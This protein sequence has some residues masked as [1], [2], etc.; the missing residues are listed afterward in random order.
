MIDNGRDDVA[1]HCVDS[2]PE[3][4]VSLTSR[5]RLATTLDHRQP[6]HVCVDLGAYTA[7]GICAAPLS[8]LRRALTGD[9]TFRV[10]LFEPFLGLGEVDEPV[11]RAI[12]A[13][14][15]GLWT[16][17]TIMGFRNA[18]WKPWTVPD[19]TPVLV[20]SEF[21]PAEGANG[22]LL[23]YPGNDRTVAPSARMLPGGYYFD[24]IIRQEPI[25]DDHLDPSGNREDFRILPD[26]LVADAARDAE[27]LWT[28]TDYA[29]F[30]R[31]PGLWFTDP[32]MCAGPGLKHSRGIRDEV[33]WL[34]SLATRRDLIHAI[35]EHETEIALQNL[36]RLASA[37]GDR[38]AVVKVCSAD[39]GGQAATLISR[40]T[41][42]E[43]FSPYYR[44]LNAAFHE[45]TNWK[46]FKHSD[47]SMYDL[48]PDLIEDGFDIL[49]PVQTSAAKMDPRTLKREFGDH[50]VLWGG[51]VE[52]QTTLPF[53]T[54]EEVYRE[55]RERIDIFN[56]GGGYVFAAIHNIQ[57]GVPVPN[58]LAMIQAVRDS[59]GGGPWSDAVG[60]TGG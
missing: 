4:A 43:L 60:Q 41:Y 47:G 21:E 7:S 8:G 33:E 29:V 2:S 40:E 14:L 34:I 58:L 13:D 49:N 45:Q 57:P 27:Q 50:L 25:D 46:T 54:P 24:A 5:Q 26:A 42:R 30:L 20:S 22:D 19:G 56:D 55:V 39:L 6:D 36:P 12:G 35:F 48:I 28:E 11:R 16:F 10:R 15:V 53:G 23:L 31:F 32:V 17:P 18:A 9:E 38:V 1:Q 52:T 3:A 37:L 44:R 51:G 59:W